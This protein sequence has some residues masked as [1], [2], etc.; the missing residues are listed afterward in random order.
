MFFPQKVE[1]SLEKTFMPRTE[2]FDFEI[3]LATKVEGDF[4]YVLEHNFHFGEY[5]HITI[6]AEALQEKGS[7]KATDV[8]EIYDAYLKQKIIIKIDTICDIY[9]FQLKTLSQSEHG[10]DLSVQGLSFAMVVPFN[11]SLT[12]KGSLEVLDV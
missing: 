6:N 10:F 5:E 2:G 8:L 12:L 9:Y 11:E 7:I 1:T 3:S 4:N